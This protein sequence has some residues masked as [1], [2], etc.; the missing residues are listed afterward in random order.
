MSDNDPEN[1][2]ND[3]IVEEFGLLSIVEDI[4]DG[5][6]GCTLC[7]SL[8]IVKIQVFFRSSPEWPDGSACPVLL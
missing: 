3:A 4:A 7:T 8:K 6:G 1:A 5:Q 2:V